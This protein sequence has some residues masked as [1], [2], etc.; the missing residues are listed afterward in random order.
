MKNISHTLRFQFNDLKHN[1]ISY[2]LHKHLNI[3]QLNVHSK[4]MN[5]LAQLHTKLMGDVYANV[6]VTLLDH[7]LVIKSQ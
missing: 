3:M 5:V 6:F 7:P 2:S 1:G 4:T